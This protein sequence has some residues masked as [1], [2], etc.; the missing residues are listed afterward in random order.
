MPAKVNPDK[1][2]GCGT[3][4]DECP[5]ESISLNKESIAVVNEDE[6]T[7]CGLCVDTCAQSAITLED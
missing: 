1:C 6:C 4:V 7:E 5:N 3:C 2:T